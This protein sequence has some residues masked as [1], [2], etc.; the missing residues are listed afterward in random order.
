MTAVPGLG[1]LLP[2][3]YGRHLAHAL[4]SAGWFLWLVMGEKLAQPWG[5]SFRAKTR[6]WTW[7]GGG[8][9]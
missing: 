5:V 2:D 4:T 9:R 1:R 3:F 8:F 7:G 6:A